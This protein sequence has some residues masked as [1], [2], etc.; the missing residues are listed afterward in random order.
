MIKCENKLLFIY[1]TSAV[2]F[3]QFVVLQQ[4]DFSLEYRNYDLLCLGKIHFNFFL[5]YVTKRIDN[6]KFV[7]LLLLQKKIISLVKKKNRYKILFYL[8]FFKTISVE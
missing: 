1:Q 2:L 5:S 6:K 7:K 8:I 4:T 3:I